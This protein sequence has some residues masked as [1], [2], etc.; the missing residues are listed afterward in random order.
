MVRAAAAASAGEEVAP[1]AAAAATPNNGSAGQA[2]KQAP[3]AGTLW[4]AISLITGSTVG[5]GMLALPAVSA[6]AGIA[7]TSAALVG[8]WVLLTL[9]ALLI[10]E[11]NLA[12]RT[13]RDAAAAAAAD[14]GSGGAAPAG[15]VVTLRQMAEFSLGKAAGRGLT[16]VYLALAYSLLTAYAT[17]AAEVLDYL[18]GGGLPPLL[19]AA[20]FVGGIG[21]LLYLGGTRTI[22]AINQGLTSVLL[23]L[24]AVILCAGAS[25]SSLPHSL[26]HGIAD[27]GALQP[28][29]PII[30]L[31][32][33]FHDL[34]PVIVSYLGGDR[35]RIRTALVLGSL[36]PLGMFLSWEAVAL[37][38]L[39]SG[40]ADAPAAASVLEAGLQLAQGTG[41]PL[42]VDAAVTLDAAAAG[43]VADTSAALAVDPLEVF[44]RRAPPL[45]GR[46]VETFSFLA[47]GTSFIG[48]TL[49]LSE[50]L[51]TEVPP[52]LQE[53]SKQLKRFTGV[54]ASMLSGD[55]SDDE[56]ACLR[57]GFGH[58]EGAG[59]S[60]TWAPDALGPT[61]SLDDA[62]SAAGSSSGAAAEGGLPLDGHAVALLLTLCPPLALAAS[63][64]DNFLGALE[65]A[66][67]YFMTLLFGILP[68]VMAWQLRRKAQSRREQ[69]PPPL[70]AAPAQQEAAG[71]AQPWWQQH[72]DMVPGGPPL[73]AGL[74]SAALAI[75]LSKLAAD[76]GLIGEGGGFVQPLVEAALKPSDLPGAV[77]ALL[78]GTGLL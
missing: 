27:W 60:T 51:R 42:A 1:A 4:G 15:D 68:P 23:A 65:F 52:L 9:D 53:V 48:T 49:S 16:L 31:S 18:A 41:A 33:V 24:F 44:V 14:N 17:K 58:S 72:A 5:A 77:L 47:V 20:A 63:N 2:A 56:V 25:Q 13:A 37:S 28:V 74:F 3:P 55:A 39:P 45:I 59:C 22:D 75:Q 73:L 32:L 70:R 43:L 46:L 19:P 30:F 67:A 26:L 8:I 57:T 69:Q 66:G 76:A 64:P 7:P 12:A 54:E 11:V 62:P 35:A 38:L 10:A 50:T 6:P 21:S 34:T 29:V 61:C 36:V 78:Q 40:L 71:T